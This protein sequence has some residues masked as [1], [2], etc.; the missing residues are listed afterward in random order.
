MAGRYTKQELR[1][2]LHR[3]TFRV[4]MREGIEKL[5][6]KKVSSGCGL[7]DPYIYQCYSDMAELLKSA[8]MEIDKKVSDLIVEFLSV[9]PAENLVP[10]TVS[11]LCWLMWSA[12]WKFLM[13]DPEQTVF[14]WRYYQ[15]AYY[16]RE[17]ARIRRDN[18]QPFVAFF[19]Q[20]AKVMEIEEAMNIDVIVSNIIDNTVSAAVRIH[21]GFMKQ[22]EMTAQTLYQSVF[23]FPFHL[24]G[25][26]IWQETVNA[27][28]ALEG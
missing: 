22:D 17:L 20:I 24:M 21:L 6:V 8:Y 16:S 12:Y 13:E 26:D 1:Q 5:T 4:V 28:A 2:M 15:S 27:G 14:Y 3:S 25:M 18:F 11:R 10:S 19:M 23:A 7:S 9:N